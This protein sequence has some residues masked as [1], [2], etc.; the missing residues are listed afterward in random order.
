MFSCPSACPSSAVRRDR[1]VGPL[2]VANERG[3]ASCAMSIG[4]DSCGFS[5]VPAA[6]QVEAGAPVPEPS[7]RRPLAHRP[8]HR[9]RELWAAGSSKTAPPDWHYSCFALRTVCPA[10]VPPSIPSMLEAVRPDGKLQRLLPSAV[11][12]GNHWDRRCEEEGANER[13]RVSAANE[14]RDRSAPAKR[15]ARERVGES[16][17]RSPSVEPRSCTR[18]VPAWRW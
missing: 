7:G 15:R 11:A 2:D 18:R 10:P 9:V 8:R 6:G 16:E 14:P 4:G 17:G 1:A 3:V 5:I 12:V 13:S